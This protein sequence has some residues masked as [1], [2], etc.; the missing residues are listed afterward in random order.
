MNFTTITITV[1]GKPCY[2][3]KVNRRLNEEEV[4]AIVEE[5]MIGIDP[6]LAEVRIFHQF[7]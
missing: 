7:Q 6:A 3:H 4:H 5:G 2:T 1:A